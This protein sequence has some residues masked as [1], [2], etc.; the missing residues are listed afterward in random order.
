LAGYNTPIVSSI[1]TTAKLADVTVIEETDPTH[2]RL[3][4][5]KAVDPTTWR[6][7][8]ESDSVPNFFP[9]NRYQKGTTLYTNVN[10]PAGSSYEILTTVSSVSSTW[11]GATIFDTAK[12]YYSVGEYNF[13]IFPYAG[14]YN[15]HQIN[16]QWDT[17]DLSHPD[18]AVQV[19][20]KKPSIY[21]NYFDSSPTL[22]GYSDL[23][24]LSK[25][26]NLTFH[27]YQGRPSHYDYVYPGKKGFKKYFFS[28]YATDPTL[29]E[30][31]VIWLPF[32]DTIPSVLNLPEP[33]WYN[34][35]ATP[36]T[37]TFDFKT[38]R[39]TYY[40]LVGVYG[41]NPTINFTLANT[42]DSTTLHP[43]AFLA[44]LHP[45]LFKQPDLSTLNLIYY[46]IITNDI[47]DYKTYWINRCDVTKHS[48]I[49]LSNQIQFEHRF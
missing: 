14:L 15:L 20:F 39:P 22:Y 17:V 36:A 27:L 32:T 7:L 13:I 25:L 24:D 3:D 34:V 11:N 33:A 48:V 29:K 49:Y 40:E 23:N 46:Y 1:A 4:S 35:S 47:S 19:T 9:P 5:Y 37:A 31:A 44:S 18:T 28:S 45:K 42:P 6:N 8:P 2:F 38:Y 21:A 26:V 12:Y 16:Q 41:N 43:K 10:V 30:T